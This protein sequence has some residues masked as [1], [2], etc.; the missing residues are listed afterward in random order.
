MLAQQFVAVIMKIANKRCIAARICQTISNLAYS[1]RS[2]RSIDRDT[3]KVGP[4]LSQLDHLAR[5]RFSNSTSNL[6]PVWR[7]VPIQILCSRRG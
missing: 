2:L 4:R 5:R 3:N 7:K 1:R 6:V